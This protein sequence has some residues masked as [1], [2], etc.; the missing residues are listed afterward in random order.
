MKNNNQTQKKTIFTLNVDDYSPE[1]TKLTYPYIQAYA[2]K[3][4][5]D[6]FI[7]KERKFPKFAPVYEKLQIYELAQEMD[8]DWNI[9]IDSDAFVH[10]DMPDITTMIGK[11]TV[12]QYANDYSPVRFTPNR[13]TIRDGRWKGAC[14]WFTVA[15]NLCI[16]LWKPLEDMTME[17]AIGNI[18]PTLRE[19]NN[20]IK[21]S[22][23]IDDY[24]LT[25]NIAKY[26]LKYITLKERNL[27]L[28]NSGEFL[29]H[30][31]LRTEQGKIEG[32]KAV[33]KEAEGSQ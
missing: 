33:I 26:G 24:T 19:K 12:M 2:K 3:I 32:L 7:I 16:D 13:F 18:H 20:S 5:A 21:A 14:N 23:L 28:G 15:S 29:W 4:G 8:N 22:H 9:Y 31:Y 11:D 30:E 1:I 25:L 27:E 6:L 17:Q 10:P